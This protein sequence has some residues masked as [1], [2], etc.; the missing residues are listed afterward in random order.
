VGS[1]IICK[2]CQCSAFLLRMLFPLVYAG[3]NAN[4]VL[5]I[6]LISTNSLYQ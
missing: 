4:V 3:N 6:K 5:N 1:N 2:V